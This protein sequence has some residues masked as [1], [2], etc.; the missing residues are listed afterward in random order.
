MHKIIREITIGSLL[1]AASTVLPASAQTAVDV[2][3]NVKHITGGH[4]TFDREK[5]ITM[6]AGLQSGEWPSESVRDQFLT[7][8]DVYLGRENGTLPGNI[9]RIGEDPNKPGWPS[10]S[11]IEKTGKR[12][13]RNYNSRPVDSS[14]EARAESMMIGGSSIITPSANPCLPIKI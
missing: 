7:D 2:N 11:D 1:L 8:Y 5:Y 14:I 4:S 6:H 12:L 3:I 9:R 13:K 10:V